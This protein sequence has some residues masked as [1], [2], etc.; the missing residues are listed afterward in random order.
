MQ[1][2]H[3]PG[4]GADVEHARSVGEPRAV[5]VAGDATVEPGR[6]ATGDALVPRRVVHRPMPWPCV[7]RRPCRRVRA[8]GACV[9]VGHRAF[10]PT[11]VRHNSYE[12]E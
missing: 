5:D 8:G 11:V 9:G 1:A 12:R 6:Q 7:V 4:A 2:R 3:R 10:S